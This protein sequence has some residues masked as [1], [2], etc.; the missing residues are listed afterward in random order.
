MSSLVFDALAQAPVW[1]VWLAGIVFA[2]VRWR[3]H[4]MVSLL[5]IVGFAVLAVSR[6]LGPPAGRWLF[7]VLRNLGWRLPE[8]WL[9]GL[10]SL[11][12]SL[13]SALGWLLLLVAVFGWRDK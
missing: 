4:A 10:L 12:L 5:T 8:V 6:V 9:V 11:G 1:I 13:V 7:V 2:I 3:R